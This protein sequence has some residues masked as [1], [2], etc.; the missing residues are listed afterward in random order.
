MLRTV[1]RST[2][3]GDPE[4]LLDLVVGPARGLEARQDEVLAGVLLQR[5]RR[6]GPK[7]ARHLSSEAR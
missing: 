3:V 4:L 5:S 1:G 2:P 7:V 6:Y